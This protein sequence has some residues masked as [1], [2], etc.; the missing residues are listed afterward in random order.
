[1]VPE[2]Q[3]R[4]FVTVAYADLLYLSARLL[5]HA[6]CPR[7]TAETVAAFFV[8]ADLRGVGVQGVDYLPLILRNLRNGMIKPEAKPRIMKDK[9]ACVLVDGGGGFGQIASV[10]AADVAVER[11][12]EFGV[13]VVGIHD[14]YDVYMLGV[15]AARMAERDTIGIVMSTGASLVH[16]YGGTERRLSTNPLAFGIPRGANA[17]IIFDMSTSALSNA[18]IRHAAY[19]GEQVPRGSG[20]T[21]DGRPTTN[22]RE[23]QRG[24]ISPLAGHKGFGLAICVAMLCGPLTASSIGK[25][26][27]G[28]YDDPE[29]DTGPMGHFFMAI[30]PSK[31]LPIEEFKQRA[32]DYIEE[33]KGSRLAPGFTEIRIPGERQYKCKQESLKKGARILQA[34]WKNLIRIAEESGVPVKQIPS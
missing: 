21:V 20:L 19:H 12:R 18:R 26:L 22:P 27:A 8:E 14:A 13:G 31:F 24:A 15:Y 34:T 9:G 2:A 6:G 32:E 3:Q 33:I 16:P 7:P 10:F 29:G 25:S 4:P 1:V 23:I 28:W 17:P 30:D 11:A 5:E